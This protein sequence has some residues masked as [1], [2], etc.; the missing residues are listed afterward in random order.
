MAEESKR[1]SMKGRNKIAGLSK[2]SRGWGRAFV[3]GLKKGMEDSKTAADNGEA[4]YQR[5]GKRRE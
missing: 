2:V 3:L 5:G 1:P 4:W